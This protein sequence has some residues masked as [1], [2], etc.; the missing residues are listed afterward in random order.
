MSSSM[1]GSFTYASNVLPYRVRYSDRRTL[2][3]SVFPDCSIE[4]VAPQGTPMEDIQFRLRRR[5]AWIMRQQR[6]RAI[7]TTDPGAHLPRRRD[8]S[9]PWPPVSTEANLHESRRG[10]APWR[11][12]LC[13]R[14][15]RNQFGSSPGT[16]PEMVSDTCQSEATGA[17]RRCA[18]EIWGSYHTHARAFV[19]PV[20]GAMGQPHARRTNYS[21]LRSRARSNSMH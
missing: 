10:E 18:P 5:A 7:S 2:S 14:G 20:E 16:G 13:L 9:L 6:Y 17:L 4:V 19:S 12:A 15:S 11:P 3:I 21:E 1:Q 8:S